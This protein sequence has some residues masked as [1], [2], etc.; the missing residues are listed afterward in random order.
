M[1]VPL[2]ISWYLRIE[3][4]V[5]A[6]QSYDTGTSLLFDAIFQGLPTRRIFTLK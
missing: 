4:S 6:G 5:S 2:R 1:I 3:G